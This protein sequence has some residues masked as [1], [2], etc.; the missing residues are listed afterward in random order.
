MVRGIQSILYGIK[1]CVLNL[2]F[3]RFLVFLWVFSDLA[4]RALGFSPRG[5]R[6]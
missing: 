4:L 1:A 5:S 3:T 2:E 6:I